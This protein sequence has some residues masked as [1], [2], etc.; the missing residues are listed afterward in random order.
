[1]NGVAEEFGSMVFSDAVMRQRL[2]EDTYQRLKRT[3]RGGHKLDP[4]V[5]GTVAEVMKTWAIEKG[6]THYTHWFQPMTGL[7]PRSTRHSS[8]VPKMATPLWNSP[9]R[10]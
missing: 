8:A 4:E 7:L 10:N 5:A 2:P 3:I 9:E 6:A 1:M